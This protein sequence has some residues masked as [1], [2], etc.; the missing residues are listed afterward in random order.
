MADVNDFR[1]NELTI[2]QL[3][4][5]AVIADNNGDIVVSFHGIA[6]YYGEDLL[7]DSFVEGVLAKFPNISI[8]NESNAEY[9]VSA[10]SIYLRDEKRY[11]DEP[12]GFKGPRP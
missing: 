1:W 3:D 8:W 11:T 5:N 6:G 2:S 4:G 10:G 9:V 12:V 7:F